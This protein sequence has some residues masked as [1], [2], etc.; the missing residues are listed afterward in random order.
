MDNEDPEVPQEGDEEWMDFALSP[1]YPAALRRLASSL[2]EPHEFKVGDYVRWKPGLAN[3][4][5]PFPETVGIV[6]EVL[7][8]PM[9][10]DQDSGTPYF[11]EP[12]DIAVASLLGPEQSFV[13]FWYDS[14]RFEPADDVTG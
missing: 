1:E 12:L 4:A 13:V 2:R 6:V 10:V 14:R 11:N 5:F 3:R 8:T 9:V 7:E